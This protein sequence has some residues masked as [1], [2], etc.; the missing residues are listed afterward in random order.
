VAQAAHNGPWRLPPLVQAEVAQQEA[1][2]LAM[3]G[4]STAT[5]DAKLDEA[6]EIFTGIRRRMSWAVTT[7][8]LY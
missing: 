5:V 1:R 8:V 7:T 6:W 2:G 3:T 4:E